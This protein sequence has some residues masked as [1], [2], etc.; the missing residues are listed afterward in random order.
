MMPSKRMSSSRP[1]FESTAP[2]IFTSSLE[3]LPLPLSASGHC[4]PLNIALMCSRCFWLCLPFPY[5]SFACIRPSKISLWCIVSPD[6]LLPIS[7]SYVVAIDGQLVQKPATHGAVLHF[8]LSVR[9]GHRLPLNF[10]ETRTFLLR[11]LRPPPHFSL[12]RLQSDHVP[13]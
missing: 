2:V 5:F 10:G 9:D 11:L 7:E 8:A 12:H 4:S 6:T 1:Y 13:T 3:P